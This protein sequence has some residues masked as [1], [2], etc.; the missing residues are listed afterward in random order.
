VQATVTK[1]TETVGV[2]EEVFVV[3]QASLERLF[4]EARPEL[5]SAIAAAGSG[6]ARDADNVRDLAVIDHGR[7]R[8]HR[9]KTEA[10]WSTPAALLLIVGLAAIE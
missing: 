6:Q 3:R 7:T 1:G 5:M 2:D 8:I 9:Q 10:I 4:G